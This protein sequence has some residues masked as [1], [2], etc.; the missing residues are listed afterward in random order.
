MAAG[1]GIVRR[2]AV[3]ITAALA[4]MVTAFGVMAG[5][6]LIA[7]PWVFFVAAFVSYAADAAL[8]GR[9]VEQLLDSSQLGVAPRFLLRECLLVAVVAQAGQLRLPQAVLIGLGLAGVHATVWG[10]GH[11]CAAVE[12]RTAGVL[13]WANLT[14]DGQRHGPRQLSPVRS[15]WPPLAG[16]RGPLHLDLALVTAVA[17]AWRDGEWQR[18]LAVA[19]VLIALAGTGLLLLASA[20]LQRARRHPSP[21]QIN[22]RVGAAVAALRP[23]VAIYFSS[24][25]TSTY[26][27]NVWLDVIDKFDRPTV[28]VLGEAGHMA[29]LGPTRTPIVVLPRGADVAR[30]V[31]D[32]VRLAM[33][34]TSV[35]ANDNMLQLARVRHVLIGHGDSDKSVTH[36]PM[37]R[38]FDELWVAGPAA[39]DRYRRHDVGVRD[40]QIRFVGR[41]QLSAIEPARARHGPPFTVLYAPTW[42]GNFDT[43]DYSSIVSMGAPILR[44]LLSRGSTVRVL[45]KPHP[46][47]GQRRV[48]A[49]RAGA[50]C[51][52]LVRD[53]GPPHHLVG[54]GPTQLYGAFNDSDLLICDISSVV[55]DYLASAKPYLVT[56]PRGLDPDA[57]RA[58]MRSVTGGWLLP[59]NLDGLS[60]VLAD[61]LGLD[62]RRTQRGALAE[63]FLGTDVAGS[64][65]RFV[66]LVGATVDDQIAR[67]ERVGT[68]RPAQAPT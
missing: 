64:T 46:A 59:A 42:E 26:A 20:R 6:A 25:I 39:L 28:I 53:A 2:A 3:L 18:D 61:A 31:P 52:Q 12:D 58:E 48:A 35:I 41:P 43:S 19:V 14:V 17:V 38:A 62:S 49:G 8:A 40:E 45:F 33:Y 30:N 68:G 60:D 67:L 47:T 66:A 27:L 37:H 63:Y 32:T 11:L 15:S 29:N 51:E 21:A 5:A 54:V 56:N 1:N 4:L 24:K 13:D 50:T 7:D 23:Q 55:T 36:S 65:A 34:P 57:C 9:E 16:A 44:W 10:C 22:D